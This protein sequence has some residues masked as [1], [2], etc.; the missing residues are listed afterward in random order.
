M[1]RSKIS[2]K[3]II[4]EILLLL[5]LVGSVIWRDY[6]HLMPHGVRVFRVE[7]F[8]RQ[9]SNSIDEIVELSKKTHIQAL[10]YNLELVMDYG[11]WLENNKLF[12]DQ[13]PEL[14]EKIKDQLER[15]VEYLNSIS[16]NDKVI[17]F[18]KGYIRNLQ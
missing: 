5:F 14:K 15:A 18:F 11:V 16:A 17:I 12:L 1:E 4:F 13:N 3:W 6:P 7:R 2:I 8:A 9:S 10:T